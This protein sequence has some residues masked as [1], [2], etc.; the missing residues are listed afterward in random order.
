MP[1]LG[2]VTFPS[3]HSLEAAQSKQPYIPWENLNVYWNCER[4][5]IRWISKQKPQHVQGI[6]IVRKFSRNKFSFSNTGI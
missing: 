3:L 6:A 2:S 1:Q 5:F 4:V